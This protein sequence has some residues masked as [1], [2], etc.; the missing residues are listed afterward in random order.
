MSCTTKELLLQNVYLEEKI[1]YL[2][3]QVVLLKKEALERERS[4]GQLQAI[5]FKLENKKKTFVPGA[6]V[7]DKRVMFTCH[8][9]NATC[10][11]EKQVIDHIN[12]ERHF[13]NTKRA[14]GLCRF[15]KKCNNKLCKYKH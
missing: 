4:V 8:L 3:N 10:N 12:G 9:C 15:G 11:N 5:A 7:T 6:R 2:Q 14:P 13:R 1:L